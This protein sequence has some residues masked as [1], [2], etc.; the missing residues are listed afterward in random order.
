MKYAKLLLI[1]TLAVSVF[2]CTKEKSATAPTRTQLVSSQSW[3]FDKATVAGMDIGGQIPDCYK[4]NLITL[5]DD[6]TGLIEEGTSVCTPSSAATFTWRF[7]ATEDSL[8]LSMPVIAGF[9]GSFKIDT[10]T[11]TQ[12]K[13]SQT[14][15]VPPLN[16]PAPAVLHLKR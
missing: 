8:I 10:L 2:S 3:K 5:K 7:S 11:S 1:P 15:N 16:L 9:S 4:D 12:L 13:L 14:V 6:K